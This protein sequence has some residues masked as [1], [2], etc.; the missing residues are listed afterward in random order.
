MAPKNK[1]SH[2][3]STAVRNNDILMSCRTLVKIMQLEPTLVTQQE[4]LCI[5]VEVSTAPEDCCSFFH[6]LSIAEV[7]DFELLV[8]GI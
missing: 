1:Q 5:V 4:M 6:Q 3:F 2:I 8:P 7:E